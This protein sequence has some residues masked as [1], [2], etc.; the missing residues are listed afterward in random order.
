MLPDVIAVAYIEQEFSACAQN[1]VDV[2]QHRFV[3]ACVFEITE[4]I[5]EHERD[6]DALTGEGKRTRVTCVKLDRQSSRLRP[7]PRLLKKEGAA[8]DADEICEAA[9]RKLQSVAPLSAADVHNF[10]IFRERQQL[11]EQVNL[12]TGQFR[13]LDNVPIG[14]QVKLIKNLVPPNRRHPRFEIGERTGCGRAEF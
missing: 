8:I 14:F 6:L 11:Q 4:T 1:S 10:C 3:I 13:V 12:A 9:A 7:Q 2:A 5:A